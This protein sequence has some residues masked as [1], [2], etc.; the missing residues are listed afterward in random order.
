[1]EQW[2]THDNSRLC[3]QEAALDQFSTRSSPKHV[4]GCLALHVTR[5]RRKLIATKRNWRSRDLE[6]QLQE[7]GSSLEPSFV[8]GRRP[9]QWSSRAASQAVAQCKKPRW[10]W[11]TC[12]WHTSWGLCTHHCSV[13]AN[14]QGQLGWNCTIEMWAIDGPLL[15]ITRRA[16]SSEIDTRLMYFWSKL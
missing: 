13:H 12:V 15:K 10:M 2:V 16:R 4:C 9:Q 7:D 3:V 14:Q 8:L 6:I 1:M 5:S 11:C